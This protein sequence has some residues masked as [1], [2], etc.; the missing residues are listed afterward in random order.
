MSYSNYLSEK[1]PEGAVS[2]N[3]LY[4]QQLPIT[5]HQLRFVRNY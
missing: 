3:F 2:H 5:R 4:Y 1:L